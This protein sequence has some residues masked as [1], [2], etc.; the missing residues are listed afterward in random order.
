MI[1]NEKYEQL[2]ANAGIR[3]TAMRLMILRTLH[4]QIHGAFS[5]QDLS[6]LLPTADNS[7]LFRSMTLFAEKQLVHQID[8]GSGIQK[9]CVC[10][11]DEHDPEHHHHGHVHLSCTVCHRTFC[12]ENIEIPQVPIPAGF[13]PV[14]AEFIVKVVCPKCKEKLYR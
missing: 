4:T 14:E 8:D 10:H 7:T 12:L 2:L 5:L 3:V 13:E 1:D 6:G 11:C 9:Y